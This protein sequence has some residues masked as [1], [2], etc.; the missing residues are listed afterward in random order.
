M[1]LNNAVTV[2]FNAMES[3]SP[4]CGRLFFTLKCSAKKAS[5]KLVNL[6]QYDLKL[7]KSISNRL[8]L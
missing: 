5:E 2:V 3:L 6:T 7:I 8:N 1:F 4:L